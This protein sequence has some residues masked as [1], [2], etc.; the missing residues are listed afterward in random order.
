MPYDQKIVK[1]ASWWKHGKHTPIN[2][3]LAEESR[4]KKPK[5]KSEMYGSVQKLMEE[6]KSRKRK[7]K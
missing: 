3:V 6:E 1:K 4:T 2:D 5:P 7:K